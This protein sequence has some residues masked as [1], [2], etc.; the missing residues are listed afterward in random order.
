MQPARNLDDTL[1]IYRALVLCCEETMESV[2]RAPVPFSRKF[3]EATETASQPTKDLR[4]FFRDFFD[5]RVTPRLREICFLDVVRTFEFMVFELVGHASGNIRK[6]VNDSTST[7]HTKKPGFPFQVCASRFV[8][9]K[10]EDVLNPGDIR[11]LGDVKEILKGK[12]RQD[13]YDSLD[14]IVTYR[15]W[16]AHGGRSSKRPAYPGD[17]PDVVKVLKDVLT[18]IR[19]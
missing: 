4:D 2:N 3:S 11:A 16:L 18:E 15:N 19:G 12:I 8:K 6:I 13:L 1:K 5:N 17:V 9:V 10:G 14:G 7:R